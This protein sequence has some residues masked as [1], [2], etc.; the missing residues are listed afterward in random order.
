M[1]DMKILFFCP[2]WGK[3]DMPWPA[4]AKQ[5]R[6][7]G[8]DGVETDIPEQ[9][10]AREELLEALDRYGLQLIAQHWETV[11][12]DFEA[13]ADQYEKRLE[14]MEAAKP[15]FINSQTG[16][17]Y[18]RFDQNRI[19]VEKANKFSAATCIPVYHET[20]RGKF[21]YAVHVV[22][23]FLDGLT[24]L[25]LTLDISH[26]CAVAE[27]LLHDQREAVEKAL[28]ATRHIHARVGSTQ[29]AQ[30]SDPREP[31]YA[32]ALDFHLACWDRVVELRKQAGASILTFTPEFGP[33][34]YM[35][36]VPRTGR[37]VADQWKLNMYMK[38]LLKNR[39]ETTITE[40]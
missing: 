30:V 9:R 24:D 23:H 33:A 12:S 19:L 32:A 20:H 2:R 40:H 6:N 11:E 35:P 3:A 34:P 28:H 26:W 13:H 17:D 1:A 29:S 37:P 31:E 10:A 16:K 39:Y 14:V 4:F 25:E 15:L 36:N 22:S 38:D 5:V 18:F 8:Y 7:A 27:T 21:S